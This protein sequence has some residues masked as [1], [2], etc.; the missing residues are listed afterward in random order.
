MARRA[1][2]D[3]NAT[4]RQ[5][6]QIRDAHVR[7]SSPRSSK[8]KMSSTTAPPVVPNANACE[9][10]APGISMSEYPIKLVAIDLDGTLLNSSKQVS[11]QTVQALRCLPGSNVKVVIASARPPRSVRHIYRALGLD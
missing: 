8:K 11:A 3:R 2:N 10:S 5:M 4:D 7:K 9:L 6:Y 1:P